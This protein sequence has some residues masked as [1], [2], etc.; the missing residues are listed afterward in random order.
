MLLE[1]N[2]PKPLAYF[3]SKGGENMW[4][5]KSVQVGSSINEWGIFYREVTQLVWAAIDRHLSEHNLSLLRVNPINVHDTK[6]YYYVW[7]ASQTNVYD[8]QEW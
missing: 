6:K 1:Y 8:Y 4:G 7:I 3:W 2:L 5:N